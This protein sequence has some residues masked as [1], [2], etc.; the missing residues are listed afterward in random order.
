MGPINLLV[1]HLRPMCY[2]VIIHLILMLKI[3]RST[4]T[5]YRNT[6]RSDAKI[7]VAFADIMLFYHVA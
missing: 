7:G 1:G 5:Q 4:I 6:H 2:I 3:E